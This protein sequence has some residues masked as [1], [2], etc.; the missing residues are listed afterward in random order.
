MSN[1]RPG[2]EVTQEIS[3]TSTTAASP[4]L[5]PCVVG[6]CYQIVEALDSEGAVSADAKYEDESYNQASLLIPQASY[7]DPRSNIDELNIDEASVKA[8][9][10]YGGSLSELSRGSNDSFGQAFLKAGNLSTKAAFRSSVSNSFAFSS[11]GD[12]LIIAFDVPNAEDT[13]EDVTVT[14]S[15]T[16]TDV[17]EL[18]DDIND[19]VGATVASVYTPDSGTTNYLEVSSTV[20]GAT[21]SITLRAG[22]AALS[23]LFGASFDDSL[24]YR[25]EG[26]GF[27]GQDDEDGDLTTP[28]IEF[29]RGMYLEDGVEVSDFP[30]S[31]SAPTANKLW[32]ILIDLDGEYL[33]A[34]QAAVTF[35]GSGADVPLSPATTT[36]PGDQ[37]W[38]DGTKVKSAQVI[39][40]ESSRF[41]L[42]TL[43]NKLS[44]FDNDGNPTNRVYDTVE[45][46]TIYHGT[47][48]APKYAYFRADGLE[49]G[50]IS[51]EGAAATITGTEQGFEERAAIVQSSA[52]ITFPINLAGLTLLWTL[53]EDGVQADQET[54]TF[55]GGPFASISD[56]VTAIENDFAGVTVSNSGN[57]LVFSTTKTGADQGISI[58]SQGT[59][60]SALNFSTSSATA[61]T[62][63]DV[64]FC[65]QAAITGQPF[66]LPMSDLNGKTFS[67]TVVDSKGTHTLSATLGSSPTTH[68]ALMAALSTAFAGDG[69]STIAD[70]GI[71]VATLSATST[72]GSIVLTVTT[73]EGGASVT[74]SLDATDVN[75]GF[76]YVGFYDNAGDEPA[77]REGSI[78][79]FAIA[80]LNGHTLTATYNDGSPHPL[81]D[82]LGASEG[83]AGTA[84]AL[85]ALLNARNN[86]IKIGGSGDRVVQYYVTA[87]GAVGVRTMLG[88]ATYSLSVTQTAGTAGEDLGFSAGSDSG[89]ASVGNADDTG[90]DGLKGNAIGFYLDECPTVF[91]VT[92]TTN[93][94]ADAI[95]DINTL[96][97]AATDVAS[98]D[99]QALVLTST[100]A[101]AASKVEINTTSPYDTVATLLGLS[102]SASGSGRPNPDF[103][104]DVDGS[105]NIGPMIIRSATTGVPFSIASGVAVLYIAYTALRL[106]VTAMADNVSLLTFG[107]T[108]DMEEAIGPISVDNPLALGTFLAMQNSTSNEVSCFGIDEVNDAAPTGT[109]DAWARALDF[110]ESR[111]VYALAPLSGD[112]YIISL[113]ST[114]VQTMSLPANRSERI[115]LLWTDTP[116]REVATTVIS[117]EAGQGNGTDNSFTLD[118]SPSAALAALGIA[119]GDVEYDTQLYLELL[120]T[121]NGSTE[122]RRYSVENVNNTVL[123]LRTSFSSSENTD[124]FFST[125]TLDGDLSETE[126]TLFVRGAELLVSGTTR[127]D[128]GAVATQA[129]A[130]GTAFSHRRVYLFFCD[131]V[132]TS[133]DGLTKNVPGYY[134]CAATAGMIGQQNP[135]QP[136]TNL[137]ITGI[138]KVYGT[139]DTFSETQMDTIGDGGRYILVNQGGL[140]ASRHS[141]STSTTSVEERELSITKSIDWLAKGLRQTNRVFIGRYVITPNFMDQLSMSNQGFLKYAVQLGVVSSAQLTDILQSEDEPDTILIEVEAGPA[142][143]CN[144]IKI[145]IVT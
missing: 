6:P 22:A 132:D 102:G 86:L 111:E 135:Q 108:S 50:N 82:A 103:Y 9:L 77:F 54:Y 56:L 23:V 119:D 67:L 38:A 30:G 16:Y 138:G 100:L 72:N 114:H 58:A 26:S 116:T 46:N 144:K 11:T 78:T 110:L 39:K 5:V 55:A 143:P 33:F 141:R 89:A 24:E 90:A 41:K 123:T 80:A 79:A 14:L 2:V 29:Y 68:T 96:V 81:A 121:N 15:G 27:R 127:T 40:A 8:Y 65:T 74:I 75:D 113:V 91:A 44:T 20:Y 139:D 88:G 84:D 1:T 105:V 137:P 134:A 51:P 63:K 61:D 107:S 85:V 64:E 34:K 83:S 140:V 97:G 13:T 45:V 93:S 66:S 128:L 28:W 142:Y 18:A 48:F 115:A 10:K 133:V 3:S 69:T 49:F 25:I 31:S 53:T 36:V 47:P 129:A 92:F 70:G 120:I 71:E 136:F 104:L 52:N 145:T 130:Q 125:T 106:D 19:A 131:S 94:L 117:G 43:N 109:I 76:R 73:I 95:D 99:T 60:N 101:G 126:W 32:A 35:T 12:P 112:E 37:F 59:A 42:G 118:E 7:P 4:A 57:R 62:G 98:E 87:T 122:L 124:S 17:Q 21:S